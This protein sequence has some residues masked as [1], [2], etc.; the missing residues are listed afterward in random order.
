MSDVTRIAE[1]GQT[2]LDRLGII[3]DPLEAP[4]VQQALL[5]I[6]EIEQAPLKGGRADIGDEDFHGTME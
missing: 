4:F 2:I 1:L 5:A 3:A 6:R